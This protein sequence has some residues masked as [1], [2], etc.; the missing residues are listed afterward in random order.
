VMGTLERCDGLSSAVP[1]GA[2][3]CACTCEKVRAQRARTE[4]TDRGVRAALIGN[5]QSLDWFY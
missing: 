5:P 1:L 3:Q 2:P 4:A